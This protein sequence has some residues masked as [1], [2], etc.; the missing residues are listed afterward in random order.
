[1]QRLKAFWIDSHRPCA[2]ALLALAIVG[3]SNR[4]AAQPPESASLDAAFATMISH[5]NDPDAA[6]NYAKIAA[7]Q[8]QAR[9]AIAPLERM[10]RADPSLDN[11]R[12][13]LA[14]LYMAVGSPAMAAIYAKE[15]LASPQIPPDVAERAKDLLAEAEKGSSR[16]LLQIDLFGG[17]RHDSDANQAT[18]LAAV[19]VFS[20][21]FGPVLVQPA[22]KAQPDWSSVITGQVS[23]RYD[24]G[25]Q[26]EGTWESNL[27]LFDQR[28]FHISHNYDLTA[29]QA[30]TGPRFG[31]GSI[32]DA[33]ISIR[34]FGSLAWLGYGGATYATLYGGGLS[35]E[36]RTPTWQASLTGVGRFG[37][38][39]DSSFR[40][41][42]R[43][44]TGPEWSMLLS[45]GYTLDTTAYLNASISWYQADAR[46]DQ[47]SRQGPG[48]YLSFNKSFVVVDRS[49][50]ILVNGSVQ[51]LRY[52]GPDPLIDPLATQV[53]TQ[54]QAGTSVTV[55]IVRGL[56]A[57][58][59]YS[60]YRNN[61]NYNIYQFYDNAFTLGLRIGL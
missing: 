39:L 23:H 51:R 57:V 44:Y 16:S 24:L 26:S 45:G 40:P 4:L 56:A 6:L 36:L 31:V 19:G 49:V 33:A 22:V 42:T 2:C 1:M 8:G 53:S 28:F 30:D 52:G 32:G 37:N 17:L 35:G 5:P 54:W 29:V 43:P 18:S 21:I 50:E 34:P 10:L 47:F 41:L 61:S 60:Y 9:I 59:Q 14:S 20:P 38:Y 46:V 13:E 25:L 7:A 58:A 11:I 48:A 15:A 3:L 55:P 27:S 12:L